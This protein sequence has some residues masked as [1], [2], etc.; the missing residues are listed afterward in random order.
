[1]VGN[2][3]L[4]APPSDGLLPDPALPLEVPG[5]PKSP[6]FPAS[7]PPQPTRG[8]TAITL[9]ETL[10]CGCFTEPS[11]VHEV[12]VSQVIGNDLGIARPRRNMSFF[13]RHWAFPEGY[14]TGIGPHAQECGIDCWP[15]YERLRT[16][17]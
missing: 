8:T 12:Y 15:G 10:R 13:C 14:L 6:G 16:R 1:M 7:A 5:P 4:P 3:E 9:R 17:G 11:F 2:D